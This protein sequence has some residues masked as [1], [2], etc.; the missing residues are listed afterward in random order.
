[1]PNVLKFILGDLPDFAADP[2]TF[3]DR[4]VIGADKPVMARFGGR[5][6]FFLARPQAIRHVLVEASEKYGKGKHQARLRPIFGDGMIT[7]SDRRWAKARAA[8]RPAVSGSGLDT[9]IDRA[10]ATLIRSIALWMRDSDQ[11]VSLH[12]FAGYLT[13]RMATSALFEYE[14]DTVETHAT[15]EAAIE[16]H[17]RLSDSMWRLIDIDAILPTPARQRYREAIANLE[18]IVGNIT[19]RPRGVLAGLAPLVTEY[20]PSVLRDETITMLIAGFETTAQVTAWMLYALASRPDIKTWLREEVDPL[21]G[22]GQD[23]Q[24]TSMRRMTRTRAFVDEILRLYPSTWWF[25]RSANV[26]DTIDGM[27]IPAGSYIFI[28]PWA[29][30]R[31]PDLWPNAQ[32]LQPQRFL[33]HAPDKFAFIPFGLGA[34]A[35]IGMHLARAEMMAIAASIIAAF[36]LLPLSGPIESLRP[37]GG[38]TLALPSAGLTAQ[39]FARSRIERRAA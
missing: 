28:C 15:Y 23:L 13:L 35:C 27:H 29:L 7:A 26:E 31:Q 4:H 14:L 11:P 1:M 22:N 16:A 5:K 3:V 12:R 33:D 34:R 20:G 39:F 9:G 17:R 10:I 38:V 37:I 24:A 32:Q 2:L 25:A 30:H 6:A 8:A 18:V 21:L 36:D 19:R